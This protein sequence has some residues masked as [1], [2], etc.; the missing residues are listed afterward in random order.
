MRM[1]KNLTPI[2]M[3]LF[4]VSVTS[5]QAQNI[6]DTR[7]LS[8]PAVSGEHIAFE[9]AGD[10]WIADLD[11]TNVHRLTS[12]VGTEASPRFS[13]DGSLIAFTAQYEGNSDVYIVS[14]EGGV[15]QR[16]TWHPG[17]DVVQGFTADG[18][19]VLFRSSR[20]VFTNRYTQLF[21]IS[22]DGGHP[23]QLPIPNANKATYSPDGRMMAY[24]P[25]SEA[26]GQWKNYRGG[27]VSRIWLYNTRNHEVEQIPQPEGRCNDTDPMWIG[28]TVYFLSDENRIINVFAYT[29]GGDKVRQLTKHKDWD[30]RWA[31]G[32]SDAIVY[33]AGGALYTLDLKSAKSTRLRIELNPDLDDARF[34][35]PG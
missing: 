26:F 33:E 23:E 2:M 30:V 35:F 8:Q 3:L 5:A 22:V 13:P 27:T 21:T 11:G 24:T 14:A 15:P 1:I 4:I 34:E 9:Y 25:L 20:A 7:L 12:H 6:H 18:S 10:L 29:P 32:T 16:L 19:A 17:A 28:D 31:N